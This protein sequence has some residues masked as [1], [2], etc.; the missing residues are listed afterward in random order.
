MAEQYDPTQGDATPRP[1]EQPAQP[2][3]TPQ[4]AGGRRVLC[5]YCGH[6]QT[7]PTRCER[8]KGLFE[9]LSRRATQIAMG[10]WYLRDEA[11]P[12]RPGCSYET[13]KRQI[14]A[15][16]VTANSIIRGPTTRQFW[17]V[18]YNVPGVAHLTGYCHRCNS[19]VN[20]TD[21]RCPSC[22]EAFGAVTGVRNELG[23]LYPTREAAEAAQ[24]ELDQERQALM[25]GQPP[26]QPAESASQQPPSARSSAGAPAAGGNLLDQVLQQPP[27]SPT[28]ASPSASPTQ[29]QA[30]DFG[31]SEPGGQT[32][33]AA[34]PGRGRSSLLLW[35]LV[36]LNAVAAAGVVLLMMLVF[37]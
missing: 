5:P 30:L 27:A 32:S 33:P 34:P 9:P 3:A 28:A 7:D 19:K 23:L 10:P 13:L 17:S 20:P 11:N 36:A 2:D 8:C 25:Q 37:R 26:G 24:R 12:F 18:A 14:E 4:S 22:G 31:P 29:P 35:L 1:P 16:R 21:P 15:G 6:L